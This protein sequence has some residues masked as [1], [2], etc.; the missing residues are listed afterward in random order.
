M[1]KKKNRG[2]KGKIQGQNILTE[3]EKRRSRSEGPTSHNRPAYAPPPE[4]AP[5]SAG[6]YAQYDKKIKIY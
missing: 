3:W 6:R 2:K 5:G 4:A 1:C